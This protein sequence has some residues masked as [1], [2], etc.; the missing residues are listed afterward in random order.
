M[1][2]LASVNTYTRFLSYLEEIP[3]TV[4]ETRSVGPIIIR[5]C[6][7][8]KSG[9]FY[10]GNGYVYFGKEKAINCNVTPGSS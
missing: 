10:Y 1:L 3:V 2:G 7:D 6:P 8:L 4:P 5:L 9:K